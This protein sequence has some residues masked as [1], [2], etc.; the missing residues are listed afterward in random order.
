MKALEEFKNVLDLVPSLLKSTPY[1]CNV[2]NHV[3]LAIL[4]VLPFEEGNLLVK[5]LVVSLDSHHLV[6]RDRKELVKKV[7]NRGL[8]RD[9]KDFS[10]GNAWT[11]IRPRYMEVAWA[12]LVWFTH[13]IPRHAF[14][15]RL[16]IE[17]KLKTQDILKQWDT[18]VAKGFNEME[19]VDYHDTFAPVA[20]FKQS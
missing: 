5:Y 15:L 1:F 8:K 18:Q 11:D 14:L 10:V 13:S 3:K 9:F 17:R 4:N 2:L 20:I 16:T 7:Q 19:G 6:Y 12:W